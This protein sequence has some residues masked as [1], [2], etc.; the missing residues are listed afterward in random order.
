MDINKENKNIQ[1]EEKPSVRINTKNYLELNVVLK[2]LVL[3]K[4]TFLF[5]RSINHTNLIH[6]QRWQ[7]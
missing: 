1:F 2:F 6:Q 4:K 5:Q 7:F 3:P